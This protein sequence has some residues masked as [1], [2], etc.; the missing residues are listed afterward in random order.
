MGVLGNSYFLCSIA[1]YEEKQ[2]QSSWPRD[3]IAHLASFLKAPNSYLC[4]VRRCFSASQ[5]QR[6]PDR[7]IQRNVEQSVDLFGPLC[8]CCFEFGASF[9]SECVGSAAAPSGE[10]RARRHRRLDCLESQHTVD[11]ILCLDLSTLFVQSPLCADLLFLRVPHLP[12]PSAAVPQGCSP[13]CLASLPFPVLE[14]LCIAN[15][16]LTSLFR[17]C[18]LSLSCISIPQ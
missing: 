10:C 3:A 9:L 12:R 16:N 11:L 5:R 15:S 8:W 4:C 6:I 13:P 7:K 1:G 18:A 14:R 17:A 2:R